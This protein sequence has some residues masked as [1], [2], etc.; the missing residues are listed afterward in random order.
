MKVIESEL[1]ANTSGKTGSVRLLLTKN[2]PVPTPAVRAG[3]PV[4]AVAGQLAAVQRIAGLVPER[5]NSFWLGQ[6]HSM[7]SPTSGEAR[8]SVRLLL[9]KNHPVPTPAFLTRAPLPSK[10]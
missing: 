7:A 1:N 5:I 3:A 6:N 10:Y 8:E 9:T 2:H 4:D